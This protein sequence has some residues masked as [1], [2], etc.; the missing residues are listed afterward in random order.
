MKLLTK[1]EARKIGSKR[2]FTGIPC[3]RGHVVERTTGDGSCVECTRLRSQAIRDSDPESAR[4]SC[5]DSELRLK[6]TNYE[7]WK[8]KR[9]KWRQAVKQKHGPIK[10]MFGVVRDRAKKHGIEF[11]I[12]RDDIIIPTHCPILGIPLFN[13]PRKQ[14]DNTPSLDRIDNTKG[15][16]KG[17]VHVI[18]LRANRIKN[19]STLAELELIVDYLKKLQAME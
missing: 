16:I 19:D 18:S 10:Y 2:Y 13:T 9:Q 6:Q 4:R 3:K 12:T 1:E 8:Q 11:N 14:T 7:L 15:Y 17:N 5:I